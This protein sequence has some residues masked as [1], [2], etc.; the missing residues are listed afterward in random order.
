MSLLLRP[1]LSAPFHKF[2]RISPDPLPAGCVALNRRYSPLYRLLRAPCHRTDALAEISQL[3]MKRGTEC[4]WLRRTGES[5][6][7]RVP[8][9]ASGQI[10]PSPCPRTLRP[11]SLRSLMN[12]PG[13]KDAN[14]RDPEERS[15]MSA[16]NYMGCILQ[17]TKALPSCCF[18]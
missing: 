6:P 18:P 11:F 8:Q 4:Q 10:H 15:L 9:H 16:K 3:L 12:N 2:L 13:G 14:G 5:D 1:R 17:H 7:Q